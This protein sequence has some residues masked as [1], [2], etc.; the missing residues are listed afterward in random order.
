MQRHLVTNIST[1][2]DV[3]TVRQG[4]RQIR[5]MNKLLTYPPCLHHKNTSLAALPMDSKYTLLEV[6][7]HML[8][9]IPLK[10]TTTYHAGNQDNF[11]TDVDVLFLQPEMATLNIKQIKGMLQQH[12]DNKM[13]ESG[14]SGDCMSAAG[15]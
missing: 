1:N 11:A 15:D 3:I 6:C 12:V 10:L 14:D 9:L 7:T 8:A 4:I 13:G 5:T 2:T